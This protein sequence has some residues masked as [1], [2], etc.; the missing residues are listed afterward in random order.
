VLRTRL[1]LCP[2]APFDLHV[3]STPPAF[4]LSQDQTLRMIRSHPLN[5]DAKGL[6]SYRLTVV[7]PRMSH[8][9]RGFPYHSLVVK[10]V[11]HKTAWHLARPRR[12]GPSVVLS[13]GY[14]GRTCQPRCAPMTRVS[15]ALRSISAFG[16]L[17]NPSAPFGAHCL[18]RVGC[19][20]LLVLTSAPT[21]FFVARVTT[22]A[23][24]LTRPIS[25]AQPA[26]LLRLAP[27]NFSPA[28]QLRR[29][30]ARP[31]VRRD[32][33]HVNDID[34][35]VPCPIQAPLV[36]RAAHRRLPCCRDQPEVQDRHR[37]IVVD[38]AW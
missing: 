4:I 2:K 26:R 7:C 35:A 22:T 28:L 3:L 17:S 29:R 32:H 19:S 31:P 12:H 24:S 6:V 36:P 8:D 1:P 23:V 38:V 20:Q 37:T 34:S 18:A 10:V 9:I 13:L 5:S 16:S 25:D 21:T 15:V 33:L 11:R 14:P 27:S 30:T